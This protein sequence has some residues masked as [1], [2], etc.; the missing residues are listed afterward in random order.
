VSGGWINGT[1]KKVFL[2]SFVKRFSSDFNKV[3]FIGILIISIV[4]I[5]SFPLSAHAHSALKNAQP[6]ENEVLESSPSKVELWFKD[7]VV[8]HSDSIIVTDS[9]GD[10][11]QNGY[12]HVDPQDPGHITVLLKE[13]PAGQYA[14]KINVITPDGYVFK[15][16]YTFVVKKEPIQPD[17]NQSEFKLI[18]STPGDGEIVKAPQKM[19]LWYTHP[20]EVVSL[21]IFN[22]KGES[23]RFKEP[24]P[25]PEDLRHLIVEFTEDA[26]S[27]TYQVTLY[28]SPKDKSMNKV[29]LDYVNVFYFA[30]DEVTSLVPAEG[31]TSTF[32]YGGLGAKQIAHWLSFLGLLTLFGGSLFHLLIATGRGNEER[33]RKVSLG[34]YILAVVGF[35]VL[36]IYRRFELPTLPL[37]ELLA[38]KFTW[39]PSLQLA[40]LSFGYWAA[41]GKLR[42]LFLGLA[43]LLWSFVTGHS[44]YPRY[45]EGWLMGVNGLHLISVSVWV[46]GLVALVVMRPKENSLAWFKEVGLAYSKWAFWS[47][48]VIIGTGV[49]M[50]YQFVPSFSL[51]S[52]MISD[53]GKSLLGKVVLVTAILVFGF[54][55]RR[56][57]KRITEGRIRPF[58]LRARTEWIYAALILFA[59]ALLIESTPSAAEQGVYPNR[60]VQDNI[61]L[62]V[63]ISPFRVGVNDI[64]LRFKNQ[65]EFERV[66]V[67]FF[68]PPL[69]WRVGNNA[70]YLGDGTYWLSGG[71]I[72]AA[73]TLKMEVEAIKPGGDKVVFPFQIVVPGEI[74]LDES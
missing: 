33:W 54:L 50:S 10:E 26:T 58:L 31:G 64:T 62:S 41:R 68:M 40:V 49:W 22:N 15:D 45:G 2:L 7:P 36:L 23:I 42:L 72:H 74:R 8:V 18:K 13:L 17:K 55:Q 47:M 6:L 53:W 71:F 59:A 52:L 3:F 30:V 48:M 4:F 67:K 73:G 70:F 63:E 28:A 37:Q 5:L 69:I 60:M 16:S 27:G 57:L 21:G 46:G 35:F 20:A 11:F 43:I 56:T 34:L 9:K 32:W 19:D 66:R 29:Q 44:T 1:E 12:P 38:L 61:E 14:V 25:D 65:P 24:Y 39:V 51:G